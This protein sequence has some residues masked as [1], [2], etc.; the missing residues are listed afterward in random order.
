MASNTAPVT[1]VIEHEQN[2]LLVDF[3]DTEQ[4]LERIAGVLE[5]PADYETIRHCAGQTIIERFDLKGTSINC[6]YHGVYECNLLKLI[7]TNFS[8]LNY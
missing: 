4:L 6:F 3:F 7:N 5:N 8:K 1:E 2:G